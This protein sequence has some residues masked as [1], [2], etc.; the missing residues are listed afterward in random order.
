MEKVKLHNFNKMSVL[1]LSNSYNLQNL[2]VNG[3]KLEY[4]K[5]SEN[6]LEKLGDVVIVTNERNQV[7]NLQAIMALPNIRHLTYKAK[8]REK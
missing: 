4:I 5:I 8:F 7:Y 2:E 1:D 6:N 3:E